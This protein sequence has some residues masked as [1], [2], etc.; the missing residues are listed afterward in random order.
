M[1]WK[2]ITFKCYQPPQSKL[3]I[4]Q[5]LIFQCRLFDLRADKEVAIYSKESIIFGVN[6]VDF[7]VSGC[8]E[9]VVLFILF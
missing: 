5:L 6:S 8:F 9:N 1:R 3:K 4:D 2:K 7:S